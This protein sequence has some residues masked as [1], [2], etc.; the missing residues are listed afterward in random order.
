MAWPHVCTIARKRGGRG[1]QSM[2]TC[3]DAVRR[4][5]EACGGA[6]DDEWA[7]AIWEGD[8]LK[9]ADR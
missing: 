1:E 5:P 8:V 4:A 7:Y 3:R 9:G 2:N 6:V